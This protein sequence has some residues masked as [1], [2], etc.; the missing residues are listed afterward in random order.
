M[1]NAIIYELGDTCPTCDGTGKVSVLEH[2]DG[3]HTPYTHPEGEPFP[4]GYMLI[5]CKMCGG[6][7]RLNRRRF[8]L[9]GAE[10]IPIARANTQLEWEIF[11]RGSDEAPPV[12]DRWFPFGFAPD[13][14]GKLV[15]CYRR[16]VLKQSEGA[17]F[18]GANDW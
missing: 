16:A 5:A 7:K 2:E 18:L 4:D 15:V 14:D 9:Q 8:Y 12:G 1:Q 13:E 17:R 10:L 11:V 6:R 3:S